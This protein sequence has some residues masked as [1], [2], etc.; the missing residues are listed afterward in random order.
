MVIKVNHLIV[1]DI[2]WLRKHELSVTVDDRRDSFHWK[3]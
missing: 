1:S 3:R 2:E